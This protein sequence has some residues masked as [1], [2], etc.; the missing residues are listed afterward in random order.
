MKV[1]IRGEKITITPA[2][3]EHIEE[4]IAKL[5]PYFKRHEGVEANVLV[6]VKEGHEQIIE[7]TV[8][9]E[10]FTLRAEEAH[11]D[12]YAAVDL[13]IDKLERQFRKNKTRLK[14]YKKETPL[15]F[16]YEDSEIDIIEEELKIVKRK[17]IDTKPMGEEEATLQMELLGHSFFVFK[18]IDEDC[19]SVIYIRKDGCYGIINVR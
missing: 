7:V 11:Q 19:V 13:V 16:D 1:N 15:E 2:M 17:E 10:S 3:K 14:K 9:T 12:L 18:N 8:P 5:N 6:K 4:K